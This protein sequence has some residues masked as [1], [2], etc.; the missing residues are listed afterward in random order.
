MT[1]IWRKGYPGDVLHVLRNGDPAEVYLFQT[2]SMSENGLRTYAVYA[3]DLWRLN[4]RLTLSPGLRFDRYRVFFPEQTHPAGLFNPTLQPFP[5]VNNVIDW[6]LL[7]PR[8]GAIYR[9][10]GRRQDAPEIQLRAVLVRPRNQPWTQREPQLDRLVA[11][12][13]VVRP[14]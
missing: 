3:S 5:A 7:A 13:L 1:D 11:A 2:P 4:G 14:E 12:L 8:I 10:G 6:N 9:S